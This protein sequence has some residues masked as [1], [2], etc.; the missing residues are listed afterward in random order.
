MKPV[1]RG[2]TL[3]ELAV[4]LAVVGVFAL[5]IVQLSARQVAQRDSE[6]ADAMLADAHN[7]VLGFVF[8]H[9]R[10]P[11]PDT[12]GDGNENCGAEVGRLPWR[13]LGL[14]A[15][16]GPA[17]RYGVYHGAVSLS[18][19]TARLETLTLLGSAL[20]ASHL[21]PA[22]SGRGLDLCASLRAA[23]SAPEAE[24]LRIV[25][26]DGST[27]P[28]AFALAHGLG[29]DADGNGSFFDASHGGADPV[30]EAPSRAQD[31][32]YRDRSV[33]MGFDA[34]WGRLSCGETYA[35]AG[36]AHPNHAASA[37]MLAQAWTDYATQL[38]IKHDIAKAS[39]ASASA[40]PLI[41]AGGAAKSV[42]DT[43]HKIA[44]TLLSKGTLGPALMPL[45][46]AGAIA[47]A[48]AIVAS[49]G[50]PIAAAIALAEAERVA[51]E[52]QSIVA[53]SA[54]GYLHPASLRAGIRNNASAAHAAGLF[55]Q[56]V[57]LVP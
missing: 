43:L 47:S 27:L 52:A 56:P 48:A 8:A 29:S 14:P 22:A 55:D 30:F 44:Q 13:S 57:G 6:A 33:A 25:Q 40:A 3:V 32:N 50:S 16:A 23:A 11:C 4:V 17:V 24:R 51:G 5:L 20:V 36:H 41:A 45:A 10:L 35:S 9:D 31:T 53:G 37:A 26:A 49:A 7:A 21:P 38:D 18:S 28:A 46:A 39:M 19:P 15:S 1:P 12:S 2:M 42:G 34:L 54:G